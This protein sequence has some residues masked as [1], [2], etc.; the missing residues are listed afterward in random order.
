MTMMYLFLDVFHGKYFIH[1]TKHT[2][3]HT[4]RY[5]MVMTTI[6][7][8]LFKIEGSNEGMSDVD[9]TDIAGTL[10]SDGMAMTYQITQHIF[11]HTPAH[12][13]THTHRCNKF[14]PQV[15]FMPYNPQNEDGTRID[16]P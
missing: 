16:P 7:K 2:H 8:S 9:E 6:Y 13:H 15:G 12:T 3:T 5:P 11:T 1:T 14:L 10:I 4:H